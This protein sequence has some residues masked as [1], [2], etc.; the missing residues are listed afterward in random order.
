MRRPSAPRLSVPGRGDGPRGSGD[1]RPGSNVRRLPDPHD[2]R[3]RLVCLAD[4]ALAARSVA[5]DVVAEV[6]QEWEAHLGKR[7][8]HQL[9]EAL[10]LLRQITDPWAGD[11]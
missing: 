5:Q 10:T 4:R 2:G 3:A 8:M 7:R 6:E 9:R 11:A 1:V